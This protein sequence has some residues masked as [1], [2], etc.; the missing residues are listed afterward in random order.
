M[1]LHL[2]SALAATLALAGSA[3][4]EKIPVLKGDDLPRHTY[5]IEGTVS[6]LVASWER[7]APLAKRVR[8]DLESDLATYD[9]RDR[10]TLQGIYGTLLTVD[11]LE[12]EWDRAL[13][14]VARLRELEDKPALK[15]TSGIGIESRIA[16][17]RSVGSAADR[18]AYLAAFRREYAARVNALPWDVVQDVV[19]GNKA[20]METIS[21]ALLRGMVA[22]QFDPMVAESG[23]LSGAVAGQVLA[24]HNAIKWTLPVKEVVIEVLGEFI[25]ANRVEKPN[26]WP[27]RDLDL[28]KAEGLAPVL[29]GVW[30]TGVD[31]GVF[32]ARMWTNAKEKRNG[33]DDGGNGFVDDGHGVGFDLHWH[34]VPGEL[35]PMDEA[36]RPT[37]ELQGRVKG[38]FDMQ[39]AID[40]PE[41]QAIRAEL[42]SLAMED[43]KSFIEDLGRYSIYAHGTHVAGIAI[44]GNPAASVL[45]AR[46]TADPR[47]VPEPPTM[48]DCERAAEGMK[49]TVEYFQKAGVRVVNM[50]WVVSR[51]SF[52]EDLEKNGIGETAEERKQMARAMFEVMKKALFEAMKGAPEILFVGGAGNSDNDIQFDEFFPPMFE[53]PNLLIAGAVDQ[54]GEATSFTSFGPT[55]NVYANGFEVE[56][57]VP[58]GD[59]IAFSGTSMASPNVANLAA[60]LFAMAPGLTPAEAAGIIRDSADEVTEGD[61]VLRVVHPRH[62]AERLESERKRAAR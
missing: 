40:S 7:L 10:T 13:E 48:E 37:P 57:F 5:E 16:A 29:V 9:I 20:Q 18:E 19:E 49:R 38:M 39:A 28:S 25:E 51:S 3:S 44:D 33:K 15:L 27:D 4:A 17:L 52:E 23:E 24:I 12:G 32:G 30:D 45:M 34:P 26:I 62:A 21:E 60:K 2:T 58:G 1:K 22:E 14:N 47:M 55:V 53:L 54:A 6:E 50:S 31:A 8:A 59:R 43:V 11:G 42:A 46:L 56:S 36:V 41:A 35:Y 61:N